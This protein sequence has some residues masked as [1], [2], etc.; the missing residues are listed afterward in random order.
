[1][2][3]RWTDLSDANLIRANLGRCDLVK[4]N[5]SRTIL[6]DANLAGAD[7]MG[8]RLFYGSASTATPRSRTE[9]PDYTTGTCTGAVIENADF[10]SAQRISEEQRQY[11]CAWGGSKTRLTIPGGCD[12]IANKLG[13]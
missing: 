9:I 13:R 1:T 2:D 6:V 10:T 4:A 5:L 11:C 3:L 7:L 8:T 12:G